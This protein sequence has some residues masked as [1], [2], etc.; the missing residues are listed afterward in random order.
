MRGHKSLRSCD[1]FAYRLPL[2]LCDTLFSQSDNVDLY[3]LSKM[4]LLSVTFTFSETFTCRSTRH[5]RQCL[6]ERIL[7][8][9]FFAASLNSLLCLAQFLFHLHSFF[10]L[11]LHLRVRLDVIRCTLSNQS[12]N[13]NLELFEKPN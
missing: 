8:G 1:H 9:N 10:L 13:T 5:A 7:I 4:I 2:M 12:S 3:A 11:L 6:K